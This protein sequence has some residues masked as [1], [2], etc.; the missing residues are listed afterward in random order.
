M[1][2]SHYLEPYGVAGHLAAQMTGVPHVVRMA[3]SDAGRLWHHPQLE[4]LY[5]HVLRS[6]ADG[7]RGR[8]RRGTRGRSAASIPRGSSPAADTRC[9]RTCSRRKARALDLAALRAEVERDPDLR[10]AALGRLRR[11]HAP[12]RHLR[13]ARRQQGIVCAARGDASA[14]AWRAS[15][16]GLVALAHGRPEIERRFRERAQELGLADRVLQI[17][18]LPHWR[19]PEFLRGCLAVCCL[20]QDFPIGFH[21]P[22]IPLEVLLCGT[23]PRRLDRGASAS[24]RNGS[25]CRTATAASRSRMSTTSRH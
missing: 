14:Q 9:R 20:E 25:G 15:N 6:A 19:V 5:D 7:G 18:F 23:L 12:F 17:P 2:F 10:D 16:V 24:F 21:S 4:A 3:G 1:I 13:Q 8:R 22:I 11:R